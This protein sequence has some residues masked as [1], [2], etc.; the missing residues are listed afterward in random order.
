[1]SKLSATSIELA[2]VPEMERQGLAEVFTPLE[3]ARYI[4][5]GNNFS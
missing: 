5:F 1:M 2:R 3:Q 4:L